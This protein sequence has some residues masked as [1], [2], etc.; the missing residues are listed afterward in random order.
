MDMKLHY[1]EHGAGEPLILLHG[2]GES[3][4]YFVHQINYFSDKFRV[5]AI[6]T[7]GHGKSP[8]GEMP[9]TIRQFAEDLMEFMDV[10][11]I[12]KAN[13]LGFS[14]GGNIA[15]I[16]ALKHPEKVKCLILNGANLDTKGVKASVQ[17]PIVAGYK[18]ASLF[19][20]ISVQ[21]KRNA[22]MLGLMVNDPDINPDELKVLD[23][24]VLVIAGQKDMIKYEHTRLIYE[25]LPNAEIAV[26]P[27]DHFIADKNSGTFNRIVG[28][29]LRRTGDH[30]LDNSC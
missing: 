18:I 22:E 28:D 2:N 16:F 20:G 21:A 19:A 26:I 15:L 30:L 23:V 17:V 24:P 27:G 14:D 5:I 13:L 1:T 11:L 6:D 10:H 12:E 7:R 8:R 29:F 9:F 4:A 3:S 25:S